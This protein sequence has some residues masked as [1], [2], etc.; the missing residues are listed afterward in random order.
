MITA[1]LLDFL[2]ALVS[3]VTGLLPTMST[4]GWLDTASGHLAT[5]LGY[6]A[7]LGAWI[8]WQVAGIVFGSLMVAL[9]VSFGIKV[10]RIVA[11]F[12]TLGGGS[13]A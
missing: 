4:P 11:S 10:V 3:F 13:A 8:P 6:G 9:G 7:A 5:V 2:G 12:L 1:K